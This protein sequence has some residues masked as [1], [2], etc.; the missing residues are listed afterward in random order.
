MKSTT[1]GADN[2]ITGLRFFGAIT[3]SVTHELNN[4]LNILEQLNGLISDR[5]ASSEDGKIPVERLESIFQKSEKHILHSIEILR[6]MNSFAHSVDQ[7][8]VV[9][10][11]GEVTGLITSLMERFA[12]LGKLHLKF[13]PPSETVSMNGNPFFYQNLLFLVI[14]A[15]IKSNSHATC[16]E[17]SLEK[18]DNIMKVL[19]TVDCRLSE[20]DNPFNHLPTREFLA[21]MDGK[22]EVIQSENSTELIVTLPLKIFIGG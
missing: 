2:A 13:H 19:I 20:A 7:S 17:I 6:K 18:T 22:Y 16:I 1:N 12:E 4:K 11:V 9:F 5:I 21:S 14:N 8:D 10:D 3:A 15:L